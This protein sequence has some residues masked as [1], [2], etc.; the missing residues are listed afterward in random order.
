MLKEG[1]MTEQRGGR[2]NLQTD[3]WE[4]TEEKQADFLSK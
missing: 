2:S 1:Q 3:G 4:S